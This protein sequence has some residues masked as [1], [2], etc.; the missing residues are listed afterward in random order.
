M[1][2][3]F[4]GDLAELTLGIRE[5]ADQLGVCLCQ[6][7]IPFA[8]TKAAGADLSV[9]LQ[10]GKGTIIYAER[11]H[12]YRAF[13]LAV[14]QLQAGKTEFSITE[15]P[16]FRMN[17]P[18]FD[19]SQGNAAFNVKTLKQVIRQL[20]LMGLNTLMLYCEDSFEVPEQ[21]YFGYMRA[22][23]WES[24]MRELDEYAYQL[25]VEMIPCIQTLAHMPDA[26]RW[27]VFSDIK[28]Y[29]ACLLVGKERTYTYIRDLITAASRPFRT[30]K[31]HIGM[32]EAWQLGRGH[33]IDEFGY[34]DPGLI[35]KEHLERVNGILNELG[36]EPMMWDDMFFRANGMGGYYQIGGKL[37]PEA[38]QSVPQGMKCI[39]WDYYHKTEEEY[40]DLMQQHLD[41]SQGNVVF[42][43]G[44]WNWLGFGLGWTKTQI[45]TEAALNVCKRMGVK[46]VFMTT[47]GDNGTECHMNATL[48]GCQ[49]YAEHGYAETIDYDKFAKRFAFCT[50]GQVEDFA[51]LELLD[52]NPQN[53]VY[54]DSSEMNAT[55]YLMWQ[56]I[57]TGLADKNIEGWELDA[58]YAQLQEKLAQAVG[59]NGQF[60]HMFEFAAQTAHVLAMKSQMGLRITAAYKAGDRDA[61]KNFAEAELPELRARVKELRR[62]HMRNWF[63]MYKPFGWDVMDLRYGGLMTRIDSAIEELKLYL[64]GEFDRLEELEETRLLYN[65]VEGPIRYMNYYGDI[66]SP[67]RIAPKA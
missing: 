16:Q 3:Y 11:C 21:P 48:I 28:D 63:E 39:Y 17:G 2:L 6:D 18:M 59:R 62:I 15:K 66:A 49:L 8:V 23:Y 56:D 41:L 20:A 5:L 40:A 52:R 64:S 44:I 50:G 53:A 4:T 7:G 43:G 36:L 29:D 38:S 58:F 51:N 37:P 26:L 33:Y 13:G 61:L 55:K 10:D 34:R 67:S 42:A 30:K 24:D 19:V 9:A 25:G 35:M 60:D 27:R 32:D 31:I 22:K 1:K 14:E 46:D 47:W 54:E 12:F 65:G 57:L 45:T